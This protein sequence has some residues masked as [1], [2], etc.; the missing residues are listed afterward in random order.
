MPGSGTLGS[1][2]LDGALMKDCKICLVQHDDEIHA[3]TLSVRGWF[4]QQVI[5]GFYEEEEE[6]ISDLESD[7]LP[8][9]IPA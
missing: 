9:A 8:A 2:L 5:Q 4:H 7:L 1:V 3:A 6:A